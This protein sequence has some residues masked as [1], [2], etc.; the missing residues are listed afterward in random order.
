MAYGT[1]PPFAAGYGYGGGAKIVYFSTNQ[2]S[3][4]GAAIYQYQNIGIAPAIMDDTDDGTI[5]QFQNIG[6]AP[7]DMGDTDDGTIYQYENV[8]VAP[9]DMDDTDDAT[10]YQYQNVVTRPAGSETKNTPT[11]N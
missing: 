1:A 11:I 3:A 6:V 2:L 5:Y 7:A 9:A 4:M 10:Q 8:G